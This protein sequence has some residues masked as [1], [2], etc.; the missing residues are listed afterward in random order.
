MKN[1]DYSIVRLLNFILLIAFLFLFRNDKIMSNYYIKIIFHITLIMAFIYAVKDILLR[2]KV[3]VK[4]EEKFKFIKIIFYILI[5]L[6]FVYFLIEE[7]V[8]VGRIL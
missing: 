8:Q 7:I 2:I 5:T 6:L 4:S 1:K 3:I